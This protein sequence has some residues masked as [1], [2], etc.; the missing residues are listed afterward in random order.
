MRVHN[1]GPRFAGELVVRLTRRSANRKP[2][3]ESFTKHVDLAAGTTKRYTFSIPLLSSTVPITIRVLSGDREVLSQQQRLVGLEHVNSL[4]SLAGLPIGAVKPFPVT[5]ARPPNGLPLFVQRREGC[6][7]VFFL[8]LDIGSYPIADW[9]GS[10]A[11]WER[12]ASAAPLRPSIQAPEGTFSSRFLSGLI[13]LSGVLSEARLIGPI[14]LAA[15]TARQ[16]FVETMVSCVV[17]T[18]Q[19]AGGNHGNS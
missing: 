1:S 18:M 10:Y 15:S 16:F 5:A 17:M 3:I 8:T 14:V 2:E 6:G 4:E 13:D 7:A 9:P 11:L 19:L 12:V